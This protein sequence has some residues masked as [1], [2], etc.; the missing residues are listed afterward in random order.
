MHCICST[1]LSLISIVPNPPPF[2]RSIF[3]IAV[4]S[5]LPAPRYAAN[6]P[7]IQGHPALR[8]CTCIVDPY[9]NQ[10]FFHRHPS[11]PLS[12]PLVIF[13]NSPFHLDGDIEIASPIPRKSM[14]SPHSTPRSSESTSFIDSWHRI[15]D[16]R[17][18]HARVGE[19]EVK[20]GRVVL[21]LLYKSREL[22]QSCSSCHSL[23][24]TPSI[25]SQYLLILS[26]PT[27]T[28]SCHHHH[29]SQRSCPCGHGLHGLCQPTPRPQPAT[30]YPIHL[31]YQ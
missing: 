3:S 2:I 27:H 29:D 18:P 21:D 19:V 15:S 6:P 12:T 4:I 24:S 28:T 23:T 14:A 9:S 7:S 13:H 17:S 16:R 25:S 11:V 5:P 31:G 30:S 1:A 8:S 10:A 22:A 20:R 26:S